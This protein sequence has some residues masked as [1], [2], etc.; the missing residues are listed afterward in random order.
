MMQFGASRAAV[1]IRLAGM[2][3]ITD[4]RKTQNAA[5]RMEAPDRLIDVET[6]RD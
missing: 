6:G 4:A 1:T 5:P 3:L 2:G